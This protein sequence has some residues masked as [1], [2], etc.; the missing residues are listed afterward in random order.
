MPFGHSAVQ[1]GL[2]GGHLTGR[3]TCANVDE[4]SELDPKVSF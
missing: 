4:V 2:S 3:A 1:G